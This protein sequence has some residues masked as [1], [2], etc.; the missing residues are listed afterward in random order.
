V[1][2]FDELFGRADIRLIRAFRIDE[3]I[4]D[5]VLQYDGKQAIHRSAA[6]RNSLQNIGA[7]MLS[8]ECPLN[9]FNLPLDTANAVEKFLFFMDRMTHRA[10]QTPLQGEK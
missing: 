9:G 4:A 1:N 2:N 8:L 7:A 10:P 5:M 6:T 3:M